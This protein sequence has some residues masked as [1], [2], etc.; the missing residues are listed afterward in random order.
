[1]RQDSFHRGSAC[2]VWWNVAQLHSQWQLK[3]LWGSSESPSFR[4]WLKRNF[5]QDLGRFRHDGEKTSQ[6]FGNPLATHFFL[7]QWCSTIN[8]K[9]WSLSEWFLPLSWLSKNPWIIPLYCID[10][11]T[12]SSRYWSYGA[13]WGTTWDH[14]GPPRWSFRLF[15]SQATCAC[16]LA[17]FPWISWSLLDGRWWDLMAGD[18]RY[19]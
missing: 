2:N 18:T 7:F 12:T 16:A 3:S 6:I 5:Q 4:C 9:G 14:M 10:L 13:F 19:T 1:M 11:S 8:Q 15:R 17:M